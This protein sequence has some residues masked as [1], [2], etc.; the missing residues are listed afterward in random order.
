MSKVLIRQVESLSQWNFKLVAAKIRSTSFKT[1]YCKY[2]LSDFIFHDFFI[3]L[4]D[5]FVYQGYF[6]TTL[7]ENMQRKD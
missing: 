5:L 3:F 1:T 2:E 6:W 7:K 4:L